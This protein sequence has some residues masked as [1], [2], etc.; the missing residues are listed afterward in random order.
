METQKIKVRKLKLTD[1]KEV[2]EL[3]LKCFPNMQPWT[4][5]QFKS[6]T[7]TFP[8]GQVCVDINGKIVASCCS[9]I[10]NF[11]QYSATDSW[12]TLTNNGYIKNHDPDGDT[13]YGIEIM[14]DPDY[15][16]MKLSRRLYEYRQK[17]VKEK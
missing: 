15:R 4:A 3:Q 13:L 16:N 14:V 9:H 10:I 6:L 5:D 7:S 12:E 8:E 1:Y 11:E 17:L 2:S